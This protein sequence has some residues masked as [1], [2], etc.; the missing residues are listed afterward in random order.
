MCINYNI[1]VSGEGLTDYF[2]SSTGMGVKQG[3]PLSPTL[4][5]LY[6]NVVA[7]D[8]ILRNL[9]GWGWLCSDVLQ[10]GAALTIRR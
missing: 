10:Q 4:I 7:E 2:K 9:I 5:G 8:F 6:K 1:N 3:C